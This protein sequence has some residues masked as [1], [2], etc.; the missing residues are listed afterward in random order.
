[1]PGEPVRR[2]VVA[3]DFS[4]TA[5]RAL[6]LAIDMA[7]ALAAQIA[8]VHVTASTVVLPPP[9]ELVPVPTVFPDLSRRVH[10]GLEARAARVREAGVGCETAALEGNDHVEIVRYAK[11]TGAYLVVMGT[12][13]RSGL[14]HAVLGSVAERV[15]HRAPCPVL[16]VPDRR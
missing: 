2:I 16:V 13:G 15:L 12:H 7:K 14:A 11:D 10:E 4:A 6:D 9:L 3:T 1:M 8:I 5:D